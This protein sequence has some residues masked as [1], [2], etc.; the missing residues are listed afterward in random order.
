MPSEDTKPPDGSQDVA[1]NK[2]SEGPPLKYEGLTETEV[3]FIDH[4]MVQFVPDG[5]VVLSFFQG[6][7]PFV[8]SAEEYRKLEAV[9]IQCVARLI[10]TPLQFERLLSLYET[11]LKQQQERLESVEQSQEDSSNEHTTR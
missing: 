5:M 6:E 2:L 11:V 9:T 3:V 8:G 10:M 7:Q 4:G 1:G